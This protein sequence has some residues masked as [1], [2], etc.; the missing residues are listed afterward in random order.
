M[1]HWKYCFFSLHVEERC[2][3]WSKSL[4]SEIS[5]FSENIFFLSPNVLDIFCVLDVFSKSAFYLIRHQ[6]NLTNNLCGSVYYLG[7]EKNGLDA[8]TTF[9]WDD[10]W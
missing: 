10:K 8:I 7:L 1:K 6:I 5:Y 2:E 3:Y 4:I 9:F